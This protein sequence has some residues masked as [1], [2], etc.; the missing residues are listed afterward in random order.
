MPRSLHALCEPGE[1]VL[2]FELA[3]GGH[4]TSAERD[5]RRSQL[6]GVRLSCSSGTSRLVDMQKGRALSRSHRPKVCSQA[7]RATAGTSI[8]HDTGQ[9]ADEVGARLVVDMAH[10][11]GLVAA[12]MHPIRSR[13]RTLAR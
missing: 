7:G 9:I 3:H 6:P 11:A 8:S 2:G 10:F 5:L 4:P 1:A 13:W 12:K